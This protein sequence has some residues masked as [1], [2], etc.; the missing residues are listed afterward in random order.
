MSALHKSELLIDRRVPHLGLI[1][2]SFYL[3]IMSY[4]VDADTISC[5]QQFNGAYSRP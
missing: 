4:R 2:P 5:L 3:I 1:I